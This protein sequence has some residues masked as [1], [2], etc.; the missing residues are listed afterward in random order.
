VKDFCGRTLNGPLN[1]AMEIPFMVRNILFPT[2]C[3]KYRYLD[4]PDKKPAQPITQTSSELTQY[5][6]PDQNQTKPE[7]TP[8]KKP[9]QTRSQTRIL[10]RQ[11]GSAH[12]GRGHR[13]GPY[14]PPSRRCGGGYHTHSPL[15]LG[16]WGGS[17]RGQPSRCPHEG[18]PGRAQQH[19]HGPSTL[20]PLHR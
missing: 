12:H 4:R 7:A 11:S 5:Q 3:E 6:N 17:A 18:C 2:V 19:A 15:G 14:D 9:D 10:T 13:R 8:D 1:H 16:E 20:R